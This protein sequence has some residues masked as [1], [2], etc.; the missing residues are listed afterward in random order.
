MVNLF[1]LSLKKN[2]YT[3][4]EQLNILL[5]IFQYLVPNGGALGNS[6]ISGNVYLTEQ[7]NDRWI[8][9]SPP[10]TLNLSGM[11]HG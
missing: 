2:I 9:G 8:A 5:L 11:L 4:N 10:K 1:E 3:Y 7:A 6:R